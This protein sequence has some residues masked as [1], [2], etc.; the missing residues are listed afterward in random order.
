MNKLS[1]SDIKSI[2]KIFEESS[3][4][5][6]QCEECQE[7]RQPDIFASVLKAKVVCIKCGK[8]ENHE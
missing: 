8:E 7:L 3:T 2:N 4:V 6:Y 1:K 5:I